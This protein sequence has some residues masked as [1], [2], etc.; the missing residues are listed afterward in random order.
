MGYVLFRLIFSAVWGIIQ[1]IL[2]IGAVGLIFIHPQWGHPGFIL[3]IAPGCIILALWWD[4][5]CREVAYKRRCG[6][7]TL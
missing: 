2:V 1:W 4:R 6:G 3:T 5:L 7:R